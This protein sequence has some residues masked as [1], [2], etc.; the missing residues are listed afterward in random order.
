MSYQHSPKQNRQQSLNPVNTLKP[1]EHR[2]IRWTV[3][4]YF[5]DG[6]Y[7]DEVLTS[8][9][10]KLDSIPGMTKALSQAISNIQKYGGELLADYGDLENGPVLVKS[11]T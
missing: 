7:R 10:T 1:S 8:Y 6:E 9:N 4:Q 5:N 3:R 2:P 11:Y